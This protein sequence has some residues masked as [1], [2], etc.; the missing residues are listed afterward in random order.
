VQIFCLVANLR[1]RAK[2]GADVKIH[3]TEIRVLR[4]MEPDGDRSWIAVAD[5]EVDVAHRRIKRVGICV[6]NRI[7]RGH[8]S[9]RRKSDARARSRSLARSEAREDHHVCYT[10]LKTGSVIGEAKDRSSR[11]IADDADTWPNKDGACEPITPGRHKHDAFACRAPC[12]VYCRLNRAAIVGLSIGA[13]AEFLCA[14]I[15]SFWIF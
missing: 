9:G 14:Q 5:L 3:V 1:E 12:F 4:N 10:G 6:R 11:T 8:T 13:G 7:I 15:N 2:S